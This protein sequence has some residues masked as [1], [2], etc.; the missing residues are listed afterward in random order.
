[1]H[2][3]SS[4]S[5]PFSVY[6]PTTSGPGPLTSAEAYAFVVGSAVILT[7][8]TRLTHFSEGTREQRAA[9]RLCAARWSTGLAHGTCPTWVPRQ[10]SCELNSSFVPLWRPVAYSGL[11][12]IDLVI[13]SVTCENAASAS[14]EQSPAAS[15]SREPKRWL[16]SRRIRRA[17]WSCGLSRSRE[18]P[19]GR[20]HP[21]HA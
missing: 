2:S 20:Q 7:S 16:Q 8:R 1:M 4:N 5:Q 3:R 14:A 17:G 9:M 21:W 13:I 11:P 18:A 10:R 6:S 19:Q 15:A 12:C